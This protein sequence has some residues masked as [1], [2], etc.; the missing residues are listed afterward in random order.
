MIGNYACFFIT[1]TY[2]IDCLILYTVFKYKLIMYNIFQ[3]YKLVFYILE[4]KI[5]A[6]ERTL[7]LFFITVNYYMDC[8]IM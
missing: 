3:L 2:Y 5:A 7:C 6:N 1:V 4:R 8:L